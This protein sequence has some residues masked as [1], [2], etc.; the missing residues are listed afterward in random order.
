VAKALFLHVPTGSRLRPDTPLNQ[1][2][3]A[4]ARAVIAQ[5]T[6][7]SDWSEL[8]LLTDTEDLIYNH[9]RLLRSLG[10]GDE[11][12]PACVHDVVPAL[13]GLR[14]VKEPWDPWST[15]DPADPPDADVYL[16]NLP[17]LEEHLDLSAWLAEHEP[18][19][20]RLLYA[21]DPAEAVALDGLTEFATARG[22]SEISRQLQRL[23]RDLGDDLSAAVGHAKE[24]VESACKH[25][26]GQTG[27]GAGAKFPQLVD[28]ALR[29]VGRHPGQV[30]AGDPDAQLL[31]Q[32]LG[33]T[34]SQ[35]Q[36][37]AGLRN[38]VGTGHGRAGDVVLDPALARLAIGQA[39]TAVTY[40]L[41]VHDEASTRPAAEVATAGTSS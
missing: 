23:H 14:E 22:L 38:R 35:L 16:D 15:S 25:V 40:L 11:D 27:P 24:L 37:I 30:D 7:R 31:K 26:L 33:A 9:G 10:F 18:R 2:K 29:A 19:L 13:L 36:A 17:V 20:H 34:T 3:L 32:L 1:L 12:Y 6:D 21:R 39:L 4:V 28:A 41:R 5:V 8:A